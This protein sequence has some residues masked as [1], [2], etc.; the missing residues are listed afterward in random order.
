M[1]T[2]QGRVGPG[3]TIE[4]KHVIC[5]NSVFLLFAVQVNLKTKKKTIFSKLSASFSALTYFHQEA[6]VC[7][8]PNKK[9]TEALRSSS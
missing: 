8:Y 7:K 5:I 2:Y 6:T 9:R 4:E 3:N 1:L